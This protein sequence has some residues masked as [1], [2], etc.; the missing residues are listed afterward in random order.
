[1]SVV[2]KQVR[3]HQR[4]AEE[5]NAE[6]ASYLGSDELRFEVKDTGYTITRNGRPAMNL[7]EGERTAIALM[8]FLKS[9]ADTG[10]DAAN[11]IVVIDDP[12]SSL[13][14]NALYC[15]FGYMRARTAQV[16]QLF[17]LTHNFTFFRQVRHWFEKMKG[18]KKPDITKRPAQFYMVRAHVNGAGRNSI[19]STLDPLL[20]DFE[21]EY[22]Y[23]FKRVVDEANRTL[24]QDTLSPYYGLPNVAR[25][26]LEA[27]LAFKI[28]GQAGEL[29]DK[30]EQVDFEVGKKS[31]I[32][33]FLHTY[34]HLDQISEPEH[35]VSI[36]SETPAILKDILALINKLDTEH[37]NGMIDRITADADKVAKAVATTSG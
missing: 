15:A 4:S 12:V 13:D 18:Q 8:Y 6:M 16:G 26:L 21:S 31:R 23:L 28:P 33:R 3:Q 37:Y 24:A 35:D 2:E 14:S 19:L 34:S 25:R 1:M 22:Q 29:Y 30:L 7:S 27:F 17:V 11:G 10:F 9:L 32:L 5:L 20:R 36:L